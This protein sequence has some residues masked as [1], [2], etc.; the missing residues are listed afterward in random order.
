[1]H[2][3]HHAHLK[4]QRSD[5]EQRFAAADRSLGVQGFEVWMRRLDPGAHSVEKQHD[6]ELV[7]LVLSGCGKLL[8]DGGPQR[9]TAPCTVLVP[10]HVPFQFV[11]YGA[12]PMQMIAVCTSTPVPTQRAG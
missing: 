8:I 1:M 9:F 6:G 7:V 12:E 5:G 10:P 2:I 3:V 4:T 11:N